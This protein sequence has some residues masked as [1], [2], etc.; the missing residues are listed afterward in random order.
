MWSLDKFYS[1]TIVKLGYGL[2]MA[3]RW[4][5]ENIVDGIVNGVGILVGQ[6]ASALRLTQTSFVRNYALAMAVGGAMILAYFLT[7]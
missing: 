4:I 5:D 3:V 1:N 7:N 2:A 6:S